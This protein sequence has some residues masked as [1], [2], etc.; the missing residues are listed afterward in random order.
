MWALE[1]KRSAAQNS[2]PDPARIPLLEQ[3]ASGVPTWNPPEE[4]TQPPSPHSPRP[5]PYEP[6]SPGAGFHAPPPPPVFHAPP[7]AYYA[8]PRVIH[9]AVFT[10]VP[11]VASSMPIHCV[12][13]YC[14]NYVV[15]VTTPVPGIL[16]WLLCTGLFLFGCVLGCCLLPCCM[17][18]FMD[19]S[20]SCPVCGQE[21]F[22]FHRL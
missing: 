1:D 15:T 18:S 21:L 8:G 11:M 22:R 13:P 7:Q 6:P 10:G 19:V 20:H 16:S 14:G 3:R 5:P 17:S 12:C 2:E 4:P 9:T